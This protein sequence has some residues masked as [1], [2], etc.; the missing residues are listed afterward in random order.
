VNNTPLT[1][2]QKEILKLLANGLADKDVGV[3]LGISLQTV[4]NNLC[5]L[6]E[7]LGAHNTTHAVSMALREGWIV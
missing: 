6:R 5:Y 1:I 7:R 3:R 4:K 2:R